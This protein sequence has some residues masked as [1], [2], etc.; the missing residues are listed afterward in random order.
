MTNALLTW[1]KSAV[2]DAI[3]DFVARVCS[4]D[5]PEF[6][7]QPERI[8]V[9]DNDGTLWSEQ[10][11]YF[12]GLF[13]FDR[14]RTLADR[15]EEWKTTQPF[16]AVLEQDWKTLGTFGERGL[17]ELVMATHSEMST[18]E[19]SALVGQWLDSARHPTLNRR[20]TELAFLPML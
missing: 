16:Q 11:F 18:D 13:L 15:H 4:E 3:A 17:L 5:S 7:P 8:A 12:Q 6:V 2:K 1:R 14:V 19:F 9:F 20:Y 10:P